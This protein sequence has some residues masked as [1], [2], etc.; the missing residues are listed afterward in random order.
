[1]DNDDSEYNVVG[2]EKFPPPTIFGSGPLVKIGFL[3]RNFLQCGI[4]FA[5]EDLRT[6]YSDVFT[7]LSIKV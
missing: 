5:T 3:L 7:L 1:M 6:L 2:V 4:F